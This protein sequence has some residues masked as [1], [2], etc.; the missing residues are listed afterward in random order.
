MR[1]GVQVGHG[2]NT[3][4]MTKARWE[5]EWAE[6]WKTYPYLGYRRIKNDV[7]VQL[8][9]RLGT[10]IPDPESNGSIYS[11]WRST[12]A[13]VVID[14]I[15][16]E[17]QQQHSLTSDYTFTVEI[18]DRTKELLEQRKH[19]LERD[20][21]NGISPGRYRTDYTKNGKGATI[22]FLW[23]RRKNKA[24]YFLICRQIKYK[25]GKVK[26]DQWAASRTKT[27]AEKLAWSRYQ[28]VVDAE[29][30]RQDE[31]SV[32]EVKTAL[33]EISV[34]TPETTDCMA[35]ARAAKQRIADAYQAQCDRAAHA[36]ASKDARQ[37][38]Q[39]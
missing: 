36:R 21:E 8:N 12:A 17:I 6:V 18:V 10:E 29:K 4:P 14:E 23:Y 39:T 32:K 1:E 26:S 19:R 31:K 11:H 24:G 38:A 30:V 13:Q 33:R 34:I 35:M 5:I 27:G 3:G 20:F 2:M 22:S 37:A 25:N 16:A 9:K 15:M 7:Q 28:K